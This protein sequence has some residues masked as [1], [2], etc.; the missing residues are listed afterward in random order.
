MRIALFVLLLVSFTAQ[1]KPL[2]YSKFFAIDLEAPLPE[3]DDLYKRY[4]EASPEYDR[5]YQQYFSIGKKFN[6]IFKQ[7]IDVYGSSEQRM[8][9]ANEDA[10]IEMLNSVPKETWQYIGPYLH[11]TAGISEK[12]LNMPGIK[13][14]KNKFP[15]R[16]APQLQDIKDL[17]FLPPHMYYIL[18]PEIWPQFYENKEY[19]ATPQKRYYPKTGYDQKYY[20]KLKSLV[21][22][23]DF[24]FPQTATKKSLADIRTTNIQANSPLTLGD[25][26]A[27]LKT[28]APINDF[29]KKGLS[30]NL[31]KINSAGS[32]LDI[33]EAQQGTA[34]PLNALK[35]V[36]NPCQREVQ[37]IIVAGL[38]QDFLGI[39]GQYGFSPETWAVTCDKTL[40]AYRVATMSIN[41]LNAVTNYK[42]GIYNDYI[43]KNLNKK[44][45]EIQL[46]TIESIIQMHKAPL[47]DVL[48]IKRDLS[49]IRKELINSKNMILTSPFAH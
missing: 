29:A 21:P 3:Y 8:K 1:A 45:Q 13:E 7:T 5:G 26:K 11:A 48:A 47:K 39:V 35:G 46:A 34:L 16:I 31:L 49:S 27:F 36:V 17:E 10:L 23:K 12:I 15:T 28:L 2:E 33:Y 9:T 38:Y 25:A 30:E 40:K 14:T 20:D 42:N 22:R 32:L 44:N 43:I 6:K 18:M 4:V 37:K 19:V 24:A 41:E